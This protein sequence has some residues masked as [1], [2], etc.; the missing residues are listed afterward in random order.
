MPSYDPPRSGDP[1]SLGDYAIVG[2]L[3]DGSQ[4]VVYLA[5]DRT[6]ARVAIKWLRFADAVSTERF[7]R[8][9]KVVQ[10][11]APFC[12]APVLATGAAQDR[13]YIVSEYV[14]GPT[15]QRVVEEQGPR[16]G[17]ALHRLAIGIATALAAIHQ[18]G[19]VHR[20]LKPANVIIA[21]DGPRVIDF[22]IARA[23]NATSTIS[24]SPV[25]TPSF[26]APEQLL[27]HQVGPAADLF[28]WACTIVYAASG[29]APF[30]S[31][32]MPAVINRVLNARPDVSGLDE[33]LVGVVHACLS[34]DPSQRPTAEQVIVRLLQHPVT[35]GG[36]LREAAAASMVDSTLAFPRHSVPPPQS[37]VAG[38]A[39]PRGPTEP[40]PGAGR[41]WVPFAPDQPPPRK[42][43]KGLVAALAAAFTAL[44][45][46]G[47]AVLVPWGRVFDR[48]APSTPSAASVPP[49]HPAG[50]TQGVTRLRP[51]NTEAT[52]YERADDAIRL[53]GYDLYDSKTKEWV[54]YARDSLTGPFRRYAGK[55]ET[56]LS[57]DGRLVAT[58]P[59]FYSSGAYDTIEIIDTST[60]EKRAT[61]KTV[62][63][64]QISAIQGWSKDGSKILLNIEEGQD[65]SW[66]N[67]G[68][69]IVDV[70]ARK[71]TPVKVPG[72]SKDVPGFGW[73]GQTR[74]VVNLYGSDLRFF[75][76]SG[77]RLRDAVNVGELPVGTQDIFSPSGRS[78]A[79]KCAD[80]D[81]GEFCLWDTESGKSLH[82]VA[83]ACDMYLGWYD[84]GHLYCWESD[85]DTKA[86]VVV[87]DFT[88]TEVR[89]LLD[90][91][92]AVNFSP[93]FTTMQ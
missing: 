63:S 77:K 16:T 48:A 90:T 54:N 83:T 19:I 88:G 71:A 50:P 74:G 44:L 81:D 91:P 6:G 14:E 92:N 24:S 51:L 57:P 47:A 13:P 46:V 37:P 93:T 7:L 9:V 8:E 33:P 66:R 67:P 55:A 20:D 80:G 86:R 76:S 45:L 5:T 61:I 10:Q 32:T 72:D 41:G 49:S 85:N 25:G 12:T 38:R 78:F 18:A 34:K 29:R 73:D 1:A 82:K 40:P 79:T 75:D 30:G 84:E 87:V 89:T 56:R 28:A 59:N 60:R 42:S 22:G 70:A 69:V 58:R 53:T 64:P 43:R 3:G 27:G 21:A 11:V 62:Q 31:D 23:L 26:M 52:L 2:R 39:P 17:A 36:M 35:P 4:G 15:L 68:F 65:E